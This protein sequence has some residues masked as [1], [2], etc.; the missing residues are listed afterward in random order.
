MSNFKSVKNKVLSN[1]LWVILEKSLSIFGLIF[2]T[3]LVAKYIGPENFGKL[4]FASSIFAV[5]QTIAMFG[6][7]NI[8]F[9]KT[10]INLKIGQ[11]IIET[12]RI[13]RNIIYF[14]LA[15]ILNIYLYYSVDNLTFYFSLA[16]C[17]AIFFSLQDIYSIY[18]D[19]QLKSKINVICN[20][21][22]LCASLLSRY[23]IVELEADVIW[24]CLPIVLISLVPYII[25]QYI[26]SNKK[27][28]ISQ[29]SKSRTLV[30]QKYMLG[31]G[32]NLM[33]YS[34]S[35]VLYTKICQLFLGFKSQYELGIYS[36]A[37]TLGTSYYFVLSAIIS[38]YM[39][40]VYKEKDIK[41]SSEMLSLLNF[42][43]IFISIGAFIFIYLFGDL[44]INWLYGTEYK[45]VNTIILYM[46]IVCMFSG[47]STVSDKY[48]IGF[49]QHS[50]LRK[51][52]TVLVITNIVMSYF[53]IKFYGIYGAVISIFITE[54]IS[55]T[56]AN[57]FFKNGLLFKV[58]IN[59]FNIKRFIGHN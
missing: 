1:T 27:L 46:V 10:S 15:L 38:S 31:V 51:K 17:L 36:I 26:Y 49:N 35:V 53:L 52:T 29:L 50:Y 32:R 8:I 45:Q 20:V 3:S 39:T 28:K 37:I 2:V 43:V 42:F 25:R 58:L 23:I 16:T 33:L 24:F 22:G 12:T 4:T 44:L 59:S 30:Y 11:R 14:I 19:A 54:F 55:A 41:K 21:I 9:Q 34:L 48:I 57:Y 7:E 13:I 18:F 56:I 6:S 5:V 47:L 40:Q